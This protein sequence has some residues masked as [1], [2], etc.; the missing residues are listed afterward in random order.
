M[1]IIIR[2]WIILLMV[3]G[4]SPGS[5]EGADNVD[6]ISNWAPNEFRELLDAEYRNDTVFVVGVSGFNIVDV[7][8]PID[9]IGLGI[10]T[11]EGHPYVRFYH[12]AVGDGIAYGFGREDG[13]FIISF[14]G[15]GQPELVGVYQHNN[16]AFEDGLIRGDMLFATAH[17]NGVYILN[18]G[19]NGELDR[20]F[21]VS[22]ELENAIA[23]ALKDDF[24]FVA[25]GVG[26]IVVYD[27]SVPQTPVF[28][29][30]INTTG[31]AQDIDFSDD[32]AIVAVGGLGV[33]IIDFSNVAN[34]EF[35]SNIT[36]NGSAFNLSVENGFAYVARW[37]TVEV[38]DV[39]DPQNPVLAGWEDTRTRA[40]G[41]A[42]NDSIIFVADWSHLEIYGFG[43]SIQ[44]DIHLDFTAIDMGE[45]MPGEVADTSFYVYNTGGASLNIFNIAGMNDVFSVVPTSAVIPSDSSF[46]FQLF[47]EPANSEYDF[48][49]IIFQSDDPDEVTKSFTAFGNGSLR[50]NIGDPA[51]DF[52]HMGIDDIEYT[53]SDYYGQ[54]VLIAFFASW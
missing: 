19:E 42:V 44:Q 20:L 43:R 22:S 45:V 17:R 32:N 52:T 2:T 35:I 1:R 23:L 48:A 47:F 31:A 3:S 10:F 53:L 24:L 36:G 6:W 40:M 50:L 4:L 13:I 39:S 33:D 16:V 49:N 9:P 41:L 29:S 12:V 14:E 8:D 21:I 25:D 15:D 5:A 37:E 28:V 51:P 7:S 46:E 30:Q 38:I 54:V 27:I 11:P 18:I 34:P 26:G